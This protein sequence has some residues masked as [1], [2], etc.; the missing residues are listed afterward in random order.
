[1]KKKNSAIMQMM[2]GNRGNM[3]ALKYSKEYRKL[4]KV[5]VEKLEA[6]QEKIKDNP[7]LVKAF[8]EYVDAFE[9]EN[10]Q[11]AN[12]SYREGFAF[13]LAIGQEVFDE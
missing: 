8:D 6:F 5:A 1:M 9:D 12:E 4:L 10:A 3:E 2:M 7:E 11:Y 13:G